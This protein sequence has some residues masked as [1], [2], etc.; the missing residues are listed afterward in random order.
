LLTVLEWF[1]PIA[2]YWVAAHALGFDLPFVLFVATIPIVFLVARLPISLGG[3]GVLEGSFV[4]LA[5]LLGIA[6]DDAFSIVILCRIAELIALV[7][8]AVAYLLVREEV[9]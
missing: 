6:A 4:V 2:W 1:F 3:M 9:R 8:G 5:G 7:P